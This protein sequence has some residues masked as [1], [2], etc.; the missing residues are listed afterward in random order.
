MACRQVSVGFFAGRAPSPAYTRQ[1]RPSYQPTKG[2]CMD[3]PPSRFRSRTCGSVSDA[4]PESGRAFQN[5]LSPVTACGLRDPCRWIA[6]LAISAL[7]ALGVPR[8]ALRRRRVIRSTKV[9]LVAAAILTAHA[10]LFGNSGGG[11]GCR[12][13]GRRSTRRHTLRQYRGRRPCDPIGCV[14]A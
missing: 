12:D 1:R 2:N 6:A 8:L 7:L 11:L 14:S 10:R 5:S 4:N 3:A 13:R 9:D